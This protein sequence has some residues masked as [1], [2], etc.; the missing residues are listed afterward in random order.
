MNV[1]VNEDCIGCELCVEMCPDVFEMGDGVAQVKT[2]PIPGAHESKA[3][4][5]ADACPTAAIEVEE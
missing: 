3:R 2:N 4:E 5:A 1:T